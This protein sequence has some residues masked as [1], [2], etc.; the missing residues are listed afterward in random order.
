MLE[1]PMGCSWQIATKVAVDRASPVDYSEAHYTEQCERSSAN[2]MSD[3]QRSDQQNNII[4][5][6]EFYKSLRSSERSEC[7]STE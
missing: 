2:A 5:L 3:L 7:S 1:R 4:Y 6:W